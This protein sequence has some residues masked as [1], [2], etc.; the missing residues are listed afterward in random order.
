MA[1]L[2]FENL[3]LEKAGDILKIRL[4]GLFELDMPLDELPWE[5]GFTVGRSYIEVDGA[6][7]DEL[8]RKFNRLLAGRLHRLKNR[9]NGRKAVYIHRNSG[10]PLIGALYFGIVDK[11]SDMIEVKP[12]TGC[13][14]SCVFCSVGEGLY[15]GMTDYVVEEDYL[16][17]E[18]EKLLE[19][20]ACRGMKVFINPHGEPLLYSGIVSLV[21]R[22]A[23]IK[24]VGL[25][26][27][28][29]NG[30]MLSEKLIDR[31]AQ[32]GISQINISIN[33]L[34]RERGRELSGNAYDSGHVKRMAEHASK[35]MDVVIAPVWLRGVNDNDVEELIMLARKLGCGIGIQKFTSHKRGRKPAKE[36]SWDEFYEKLREW[37]EKH[38]IKL[39]HEV[40]KEPARTREL[41]MPFRKG[42]TVT[43]EV[44]CRGRKGKEMIAAA[45]QRSIVVFNCAERPGRRI[46][47]RILTAK[48]NLFTG[49]MA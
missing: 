27:M 41:P 14:I 5:Q 21:R 34:D 23:G 38:G 12:V 20:K 40:M 47:A 4:M 24:W 11:G 22:I 44:M 3:E 48:H 28:M 8:E 33:T 35:K 10:I 42:D 26:S 30:M 19:F 17:E 13:N 36:A 43:A 15:P 45:G 37:G 25:V 49:E 18:L 39:G 29:T 16:V 1:R 2:E 32:A 7:E 9:L 31:L 46:K 6:G